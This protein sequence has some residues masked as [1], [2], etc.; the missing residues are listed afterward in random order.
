MP[1]I[2]SGTT[3]TKRAAA[4]IAFSAAETVLTAAEICVSA[5]AGISPCDSCSS[6]FGADGNGT[7]VTSSTSLP[8]TTLPAAVAAAWLAGPEGAESPTV[9]DCGSCGGTTT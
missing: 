3:A 4:E 8:I 6:A 9:D 2:Y 5:A 7:G 1:G